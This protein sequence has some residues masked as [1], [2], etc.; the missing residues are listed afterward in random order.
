MHLE[1]LVQVLTGQTQVFTGMKELMHSSI[2]N[3]IVVQPCCWQ[4]LSGIAKTPRPCSAQQH[5]LY[6]PT[7]ISCL[8]Q[9]TVLVSIDIQALLAVPVLK[10]VVRVLGE[11]LRGLPCTRNWH[12]AG[13]KVGHDVLHLLQTASI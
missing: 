10:A 13:G 2:N 5:T 3:D 1:H 4:H 6:V 12:P 9:Y 11:D 8:N 7:N